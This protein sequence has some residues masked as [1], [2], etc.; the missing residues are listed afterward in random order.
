MVVMLLLTVD[1]ALATGSMR[2]GGR[3]VDQGTTK[4]EVIQLCGQ[5][6]VRKEGDNYWYYDR[7]SANLVTRLFFVGEK[8]EFIDD[9]AR[10]EM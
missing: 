5:P 2:C 10:D 3:L 6:S 4:D 7:G 9:V 8:V 1:L